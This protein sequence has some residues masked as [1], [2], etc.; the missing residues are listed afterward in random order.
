MYPGGW[1]LTVIIFIVATSWALYA[2]P[3]A[4]WALLYDANKRREERQKEFCWSQQF[5]VELASCHVCWT[6]RRHDARW[7]SSMPLDAWC[8]AEYE[9][10][11]NYRGREAAFRSGDAFQAQPSCVADTHENARKTIQNIEKKCCPKMSQDCFGA[12]AELRRLDENV[13]NRWPL[14]PHSVA[15]CQHL[16]IPNPVYFAQCYE[17]IIGRVAVLF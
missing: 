9:G 15:V 7:K 14:D 4:D 3:P 16:L 17:H 2:G 6:P 8:A 11:S 5:I 10:E 13:D 1:T 12:T